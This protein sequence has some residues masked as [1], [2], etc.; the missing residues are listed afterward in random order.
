[1]PLQSRYIL[2]RLDKESHTWAA[3]SDVWVPILEKAWSEAIPF[4]SVN[5]SATIVAVFKPEAIGL[6]HGV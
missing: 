3:M 4:P 1:M 6:D 5:K 2:V